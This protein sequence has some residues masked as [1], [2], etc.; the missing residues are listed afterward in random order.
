[1]GLFYGRAKYAQCCGDM[2]GKSKN[3]FLTLFVP[4]LTHGFYDFCLFTAS[5]TENDGM[6]MVFFAFEIVV[7]IAALV[8]IHISSKK[9]TALPGMGVPFWQFPAYPYNYYADQ[10]YGQNYQQQGYYTPNGYTQPQN[11]GQNYQ[12]PQY[13]NYQQGQYNGYNGY[14]QQ[15]QDQSYQN[16]GYNNYN[17]FNG[18]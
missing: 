18:Q 2:N 17:N 1:M 10:Q 11:Y 5:D 4:I 16:N 8:L 15:Y 9:D 7:T 12:Q 14:P 3:M 6:I 13:Q